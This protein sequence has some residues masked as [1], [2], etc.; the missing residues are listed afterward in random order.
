[1]ATES[2]IELALAQAKQDK[3]MTE[4]QRKIVEAAIT[5]FAEKG[6]AATSTSEIAKASGVAEGTIFRHYGTKENLLLAI[7]LPTIVDSTLPMLAA[8]FIH[9]VLQKEHTDF[10]HF[11]RE[12]I[13]D[14]FTFMEQNKDVFK[15]LVVELLHRDELREQFFAFFEQTVFQHLDTLFT[16]FKQRGEIIDLPNPTL[17]RFMVTTIFSFFMTRFFLLP[18][19]R[20]DDEAEINATVQL[21]IHGMKTSHEV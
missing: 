7:I 17:I 16:L 13:Q 4:K 15:I 21:I 8:N 2:F 5:I 20:W 12:L 11:L 18:D 6:Y 9:D 1:M 10:E 14:R 19:K 3:K